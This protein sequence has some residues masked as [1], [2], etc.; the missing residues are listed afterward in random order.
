MLLR[1]DKLH[2]NKRTWWWWWWWRRTIRHRSAPTHATQRKKIDTASVLAYLESPASP[3]F[4][5][6]F[7]TSQRNL[8]TVSQKNCA[9]LFLP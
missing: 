4:V 6:Y 2:F 5:A 1:F 3:G 8:L 7:Y 9:K